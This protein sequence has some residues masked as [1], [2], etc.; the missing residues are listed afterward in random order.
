MKVSVSNIAWEQKDD[1]EMYLFLQKNKVEGLEIAPTRIFPE[2]PYEKL[3]EAS[4]YRRKMSEQYGLEIS[5]MQSI[6]YG[7][8]EKI[9]EDEQQ[10]QILLEYTKRAFEFAHKIRCRNLVF[11]CPRNRNMNSEDDM[12][13]AVEFFG[14]L[15]ELAQQEN[16]ILALE[17][18]PPIYHTNFLNTTA[19]T[20]EFV[21][22]MHS[23]GVKMNYDFG[24]VIQNEEDV[25]D[26]RQMF[27]E[28]NHV[29]ISEPH[30]AMIN[31]S[32]LHEK[33]IGLLKEEE[34]QGYISIEMRSLGNLESVK[35]T[36]IRLLELVKVE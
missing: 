6:W 4:E 7:R 31:Y 28:V 16:T 5:S 17:A 19:E 35:N 33:L 1:E 18:N 11:G 2:N 27:P 9:F 21:K 14:K 30:L 23:P 15:G 34:Y 22:K 36:V 29:H 20:F 26:L 3:Q 32:L 12:Q 25:F 10:R 24:V 8:I 13:I